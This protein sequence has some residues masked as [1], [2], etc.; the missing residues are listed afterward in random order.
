MSSLPLDQLEL[1]A[2][3]QRNHLR[4]RAAELKEKIAVTRE[5]FDVRRN[6]REHLGVAAGLVAA[7]AF[8]AGYAVTG[9]FLG[10]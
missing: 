10:D 9:V 3:A 8:I 7:I 1:Q 5:R 2:A 6:A 4:A